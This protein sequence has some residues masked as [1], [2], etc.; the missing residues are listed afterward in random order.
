MGRIIVTLSG[1]KSSAYC[2]YW[3]F[4][5]FPKDKIILY[6]NDTKWEHYDL[7]RFLKELSHK[8]N[9]PLTIDSDGRT[10]EQLFYDNRA[11]ANTRMPFCSRVLK[12]ERLQKFYNDGDILI[13]G[14]GTDEAHRAIRIDNRYQ[15]IAAKTKKIPE[16]RFPLLEENITKKD[17]HNFLNKYEI[18]EPL[19]Y[20]LGFLHNNCSGGCVQAG[21]KQWKMLY[22]K[23]PEIYLDRERTEENV[24]KFLN[25]D[26][27]FFKDETLRAFR[28]R[29]ENNEL[30]KYYDNSEETET[31]C[32]GVCDTQI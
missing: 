22:E 3:A 20:Q 24:R 7:Y 18:K 19:L 29:I 6:F 14:I 21:K 16:V 32:I 25:K 17:I 26:V 2:A 31:E 9:H 10:P 27:H 8:F 12:A 13:F 4:Q 1:G 11:L 23:L 5:T 30:S 28:K 15:T